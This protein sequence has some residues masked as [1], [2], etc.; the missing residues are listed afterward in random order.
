M[1]SNPSS[2]WL[3]KAGA[4]IIHTF[5]ATV[6]VLTVGLLVGYLLAYTP[7][8]FMFSRPPVYT[9]YLLIGVFLGF[10]VNRAFRSR[11]ATWTWVLPLI[12]LVIWTCDA[13]R[14]NGFRYALGYYLGGQCGGCAEVFFVTCPLNCAV[15]YSLGAWGGLK[16]KRKTLESVGR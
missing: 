4:Y 16:W 8:A 13:A 5:V 14:W 7:I 3:V 15:A 1:G 11:L 2:D 12:W 9:G 6:G 10:L